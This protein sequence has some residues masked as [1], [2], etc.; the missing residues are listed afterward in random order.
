MKEPSFKGVR[1]EDS[2]DVIDQQ[3]LLKQILTQ[4]QQNP[5]ERPSRW[6]PVRPDLDGA[7]GSIAGIPMLARL[8]SGD[9]EGSPSLS[10]TAIMRV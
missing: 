1:K 7:G 3:E 4:Q 9:K 10:S 5:N 6:S 2:T 8:G